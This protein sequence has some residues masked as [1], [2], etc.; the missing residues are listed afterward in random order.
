MQLIKKFQ[1][2]SGALY[3]S[4]TQFSFRPSLTNFEITQSGLSSLNSTN[5]NLFGVSNTAESFDI[6]K[7]L[8]QR[9]SRPTEVTETN[10]NKP[11]EFNKSI[12]IGE[13][14]GQ[15]FTNYH[16]Y[17]NTKTI[18]DVYSRI[19]SAKENKLTE[20]QQQVLQNRLDANIALDNAN[21]DKSQLTNSQRRYLG[22]DSEVDAA[23]AKH[24]KSLARQTIA[25]NIMGQV[26]DVAGSLIPKTDQSALTEGL[27][28]TYDQAS[29]MMM[30]VNPLVGGIMKAGG[31][32]SDGL[33]A[34]GVGT[35]QMTTADKILDSK[36]LKL[37]PVGLI[38]AIGAKKSDA[39]AKNDEVF[40][41]I[42]SAYEGTEADVDS[43]VSKAGK[44]YGLFSKRARQKANA[45]IAEAKTQQLIAGNIAEESSSDFDTQASMSDIYSNKSSFLS[46]GGFN[47]RMAVGKQGMKIFNK[48]SVTNIRN[49][50]KAQKGTKLP[51][52][53]WV[54]N[55]NPDFLSD[56][57]DL[58][59]AYK[60]LPIEQLN[61]WKFAVNS[62][63]ANHF[64]NVKNENG[65]YPYH[66]T[67]VAKLP[68]SD[69]YVFLKL[70]T[71]K[72]NPE[73]HYETETYYN[74]K[75]G[76]KE[77]HD[78][79]Y[80]GDR[81]YYRKK[82]SQKFENGGKVNVIPDGAL[83]ARLH[84][85]D[86]DNI[87]KK[88][89]PVVVQKEGG[90]VEQQAEIERNEIIFN[91]DL[92]KKLEELWKDGSD[93]AAIKAGELLVKEILDNTQDNTGLIKEVEV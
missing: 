45:Q 31:L 36:F 69:D 59:T 35:D 50:I 20:Q 62:G 81:Y 57:Y 42:G 19:Q 77:T 21:G 40:T 18:D 25:G 71:E 92:T 78:L 22:N 11:V 90:E 76:L 34:L 13:S 7:N 4:N 24:E 54:S 83:H 6:D 87:T 48:E 38:N 65:E 23:V 33:T 41:Q 26:S 88:G 66:L 85:M 80:D 91:L 60:Y 84:H 12:N 14:L 46:S 27:N 67:S 43:A 47:Q 61:R 44:K 79:V 32:V 63:M 53:L 5:S 2:P 64:L 55:V 3:R 49:C 37:T 68:N 10:I 1:I 89:I 72:T 74:G 52:K 17:S 39:L 15:D 8:K 29:D 75:N 16:K 28:N 9:F 58:E 73:L 93:E 30:K 70:G 51:Y 86:V 56:N 82:K